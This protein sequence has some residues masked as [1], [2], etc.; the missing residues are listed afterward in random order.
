MISSFDVAGEETETP[1][2]PYTQE[3]LFLQQKL[4]AEAVALQIVKMQLCSV[5]KAS[6]TK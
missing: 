6:N 1:H 2:H 4:H 3:L 5:F